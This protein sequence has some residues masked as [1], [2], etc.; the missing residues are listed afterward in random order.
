[1]HKHAYGSKI[2]LV[3]ITLYMISITALH[4]HSI[5]LLRFI[6]DYGLARE[7][8]KLVD[9]AI[10]MLIILALLLVLELI[11]T[12]L[13]PLYLSKSMV[14][15]KQAY[16]DRVLDQDI[17][18]VQKEQVNRYL[19]NLTNDFDRYEMKFIKNL[20][21]LIFVGL[22]FGMSIVLLAMVH[23]GLVVVAMILLLVFVKFTSRTSKPVQKTEAKKSASLEAYTDF[24]NESLQ[25]F[26]IIKQ[27]QLESER[28]DAFHAHA[29]A[30]Q[31]DNYKVDVKTT[32]VDALNNLV[33][34]VVLFT[35][36]GGGILVAR[37]TALS[38]GSLIVIVSSFG[39]AMWPLSEF[40]PLLSQMKGITQVLIDF[41]KNL[42]RPNYHRPIHVQTFEDVTFKQN[43]L[44]YS[45]EEA[46]ILHDV[47]FSIK[48]GEKVLI[49]GRSGSGKSTLLKTLRQSLL[50]KKG[51]I[52][53]N[54]HDIQS[55]DPHDYHRLFSTVDQIGFI[56]NGS[57]KDNLDLYQDMEPMILK[58]V[59]KQVGLES[60]DL[61]QKLINNGS[62]LSGG[63][64]ARLMLA[65]ALCLDSSIILCDEIFANLEYSIAKSIEADLLNVK[66]TLIN[67][68][69]I[70]FKENLGSYDRIFI[71]ED[72]KVQESHDLSDIWSRMLDEN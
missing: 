45:D 39:N 37:S 38:L 10:Q 5:Y 59:M 18:Q 60:L 17:T 31:N 7:M 55:I 58:S 53:L 2:W 28:Y 30:V 49:V 9:V 36:I 54:H 32:Q 12:P 40:S 33:Q 24:V 15:M 1:M 48:A 41:E 23:L 70:I 3:I 61:Q 27:H 46:S 11:G 21:Q 20:M 14:V 52:Y 29:V 67:V 72:G 34:T 68:S 4:G 57:V 19:S 50:P 35:L 65:R 42:T 64:R 13:R 51:L 69:H 63:Q 22:R 71:V 44:G 26:E 66:K 43:D 62:N 6:T 16:I 25:G 8:D 47:D 56:F